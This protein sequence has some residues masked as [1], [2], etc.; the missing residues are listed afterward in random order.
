MSPFLG[1]LDILVNNPSSTGVIPHADLRALIEE[2]GSHV[3]R[4]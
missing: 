2:S 3:T 1:R 4:R